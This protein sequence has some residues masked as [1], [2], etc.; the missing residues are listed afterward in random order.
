MLC[1][2]NFLIIFLL[3]KYGRDW[4]ACRNLQELTEGWS[5]FDDNF[6]PF[7]LLGRLG[8]YLEK[9]LSFWSQE[10]NHINQVLIT[11]RL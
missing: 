11:M 6:D 3:V 1:G 2:N 10:D 7:T 4:W 9:K 5:S 8:I